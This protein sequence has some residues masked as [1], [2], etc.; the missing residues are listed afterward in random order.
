M[1]GLK[2]I[3]LI[4]NCI[5]TKCFW[6]CQ[7]QIDRCGGSVGGLQSSLLRGNDKTFFCEYVRF[8]PFRNIFWGPQKNALEQLSTPY[9]STRSSHA[10]S[11]I[12]LCASTH[13]SLSS[14]D[15]LKKEINKLWNQ[16]QY[17]HKKTSG[18]FIDTEILLRLFCMKICP[19]RSK[20][21]RGLPFL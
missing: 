15:N 7:A 16:S 2:S 11:K 13:A 12:G 8:V 17:T 1:M 6:Q 18:N 21:A 20:I 3:C 9:S 5:F 19:Q 10:A 4:W 14:T